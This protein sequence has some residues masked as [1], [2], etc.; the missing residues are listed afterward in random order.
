[1][2]RGWGGPQLPVRVK[3]TPQGAQLPCRGLYAIGRSG[4]ELGD[5]EGG[6]EIALGA[7]ARLGR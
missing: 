7:T 5:G 6:K 1:M 4:A 3:G 2:E